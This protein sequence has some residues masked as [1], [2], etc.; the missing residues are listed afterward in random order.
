MGCC[1]WES[2]EQKAFPN[3]GGPVREGGREGGRER[4][5]EHERVS[6]TA[7]S[8]FSKRERGKEGCE[9]ERAGQS[10]GARLNKGPHLSSRCGLHS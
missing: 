6:Y 3:V 2:K 5:S 8:C 10:H 4:A 9:E 1:G 7:L